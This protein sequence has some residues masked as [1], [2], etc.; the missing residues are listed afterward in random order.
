MSFVGNLFLFSVVKEFWKSVKN[1]Q[2]YRYE[3]G[4]LLFG[5]QCIASE[6]GEAITRAT[7]MVPSEVSRYC[8]RSNE[9]TVIFY[10]LSLNLSA[11]QEL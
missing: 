8:K 6:K 2:S 11:K 4:V 9:A 1:W 10:F 3:F 7:T 5:T